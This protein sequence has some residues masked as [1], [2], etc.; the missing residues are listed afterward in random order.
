M[1][2]SRHIRTEVMWI[3]NLFYLTARIFSRQFSI[4]IVKF[5]AAVASSHK[6][7]ICI[8]VSQMFWTPIAAKAKSEFTI[9]YWHTANWFN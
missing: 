8:H 2:T 5:Y 4:R 6:W 9:N 1:T 7:I 3:K